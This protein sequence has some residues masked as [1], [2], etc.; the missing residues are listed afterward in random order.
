[1]LT[2]N[3]LQRGE[4]KFKSFNPEV[5]RAPRI[6]NMVD[7]EAQIE[8]EKNYHKDFFTMVGEVDKVCVEYEKKIKLEEKEPNDHAL[9][10]HGGGGEQPPP[11][12]SSS[13]SSSSSS[14]HHSNRNQNAYK[15]TLFKLDVKFDLSVLV[16]NLMHKI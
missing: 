3:K 12:P 8:E 9:V 6:E 1:M 7:E 10:N 11:S 13:E 15:N 4:G 2:M 16:E 14:S 5:G